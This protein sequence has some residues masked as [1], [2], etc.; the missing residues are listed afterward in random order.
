[1]RVPDYDRRWSR[2]FSLIELLVVL[3]ILAVLASMT[4]PVAQLVVKR[5]KEQE[6]RYQLRQIRDAIDQYKSLS[7][8][9]RIRRAVGETGYPKSLDLL[10]D[11]VVDQSAPDGRKIYLLRRMP[12]D[13][14]AKEGVFGTASWGK[15]SYASPPDDPREGED[16]YDVYSLSQ[17][18]GLNGLAYRKW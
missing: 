17:E 6:L 3:V 14:W 18:L 7:D 9:G 16:I 10:V 12:T 11:G 5:Q 13:P 15:R 2:G 8:S 4:A 1:M